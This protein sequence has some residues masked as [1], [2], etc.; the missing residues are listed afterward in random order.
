MRD[1]DRLAERIA[2]C[3]AVL[4]AK[5][6]LAALPELPWVSMPWL[7]WYPADFYGNAQV[8]SF[9]ER[10]EL[11]YRRLLDTSWQMNE[12]CFIPN[13][14]ARIA[15]W[16]GCSPLDLQGDAAVVLDR[17]QRTLD[18]KYLYHPRMLR[19]YLSVLPGQIGKRKAAEETNRKRRAKRDAHRNAERSGKRDATEHGTEGRTQNS[20]PDIKNIPPRT[21]EPEILPAE[22][23]A[24]TPDGM[25]EHQLA[26]AFMENAGLPGGPP[27]LV[28]I[29]SAIRAF[30]K[31][32]GIRLCDSY[33]FIFAAAKDAM[34]DGV[35]LNRFWF[36]DQRYKPQPDVETD[37]GQQTRPSN[38]RTLSAAE[39]RTRNNL[40]AA[41]RAI[42]REIDAAKKGGDHGGA[43]AARGGN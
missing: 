21:R 26:T 14:P 19:E 35:T 40:S 33:D 29:A 16:C 37:Y 25:S 24:G 41:S 15:A 10:Q 23:A 13:E 12:P 11:W 9:S 4:D 27:E 22:T 39:R 3:V 30:A 1:A 18:G 43:H 42:Q 34:R 32:Q 20:E 28:V 36:T 38:G 8:R 6:A 7:R 31:E 17:F 5:A 2:D